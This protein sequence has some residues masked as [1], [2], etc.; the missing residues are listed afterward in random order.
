MERLQLCN[1]WRLVIDNLVESIVNATYYALIIFYRIQLCKESNNERA[2][3]K[4]L[5]KS[6]I[7]IVYFIISFS[8]YFILI[9]LIT[10]HI[11][12]NIC[13]YLLINNNKI[14]LLKKII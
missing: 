9:I 6:V 8:L 4:K 2:L 13:I 14:Y 12:L 5:S 1:S 7:N 11:I 3:S 10:L